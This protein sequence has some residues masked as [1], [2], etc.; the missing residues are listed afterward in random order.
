MARALLIIG[1]CTTLLGFVLKMIAENQEKQ[2]KAIPI[3]LQMFNMAVEHNIECDIRVT[4]QKFDSTLF[5]RMYTDTIKCYREDNIECKII[6][7][8]YETGKTTLTCI[9]SN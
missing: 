2:K 3:E 1:L 4:E 9:N 6:Y 5:E 8:T 7:L